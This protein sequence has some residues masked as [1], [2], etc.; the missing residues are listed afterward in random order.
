MSTF[1][2]KMCGGTLEIKQNAT[3]ATCD[4]CGTQQTLPKLD[5]EKRVSLYERANHFRRN[6]DF[7]KAMAVYEQ[8]LNEDQTDAEAYWS[9]VLCQY[10]I[11]YVEDP[12]S[13]RRIPTVNRVQFTSI[14][15]DDNYKSALKHADMYQRRIYEEEAKAINEIQKGILAIS[16]KEE[17]FDVFIC[18]KETDAIGKRTQDSV[19][20]QDLYYQL[21]QEGFKVFFAR[22]TL[23]D[24]LGSA[25]EPY[26]FAALNSAKV[27]VVLGTKPEH[28]NA[29]WVKNEWS[30]YLALVKNSKGQKMLIPAYRGMDPY[31]LPEE[32]SHLQAQ[33][34]SKLGF[35]QDLIRGIKK[36]LGRDKKPEA[37]VTER[38]VIQSDGHAQETAPL[39]RRAFLFLEDGEFD[40][41]DE[42]AEKVL[43]IDPECAEAY[44]VKLLIELRLRK[45]SDLPQCK[46][47]ISSSHNYQKAIRFAS[48][49]YRET[50][51][52]YNNAIINRNETAR[53]DSIYASGVEAMRYR[54]F[55]EAVEFFQRITNYKDS[56][57]KIEDCKKLKEE[58]RLNGIYQRAVQ[59][60]NGCAYDSAIALFQSIENYKD[61]QE[62]IKICRERKET[63]RKDSIYRQAMDRVSVP[64]NKLTDVDLKKS[65][66]ELQ[67]ISGYKDVDHQIRTLNTRLEKWYEDKRQ[68]EEAA[69]IK[70]EE[71]RRTQERLAEERRIKKEKQ[72]A[73]A[74]KVAKVGIPTVIAIAAVVV[75]LVTFIIPLIRYNQADELFNAG[76]YDEA[77]QIYQDI[78]GFSD[79]E[80]RIKVLYGINCIDVNDFKSGI[81]IILSAGVPVKLTYGMD[82][83]DFSGTEYANAQDENDDRIVFANASAMPHIIDPLSA[84]TEVSETVEFNYNSSAD[85]SGIQTPGRMGYRFV[86]WVLDSYS[87]QVDGIFELQ[88]NAIWSEKE[89][90]IS[91]DLDGG[92]VATNNPIEY[93]IEDSSFTLTNPTKTGYTFIGWTGTDLSEP[94]TSVTIATGSVGNRSYKAN[95][96]ANTYIITLNPN[97]GT[98]STKSITVTYDQP[99]SLPTPEWTGRNFSGWYE[100]SKK[101]ASG[102]WTRTSNLDLTAQWDIVEY[103]ITYN[104][105]G[106]VNTQSNPTTYTILDEI[107]LVQP[108]R[109]G[110]TFTG[111]TGTDLSEPT[112]VVVIDDCTGP[113]S[114]TA[115]WRANTYTITLDGNGV[116]LEDDSITV[117]YDKSYTLP[118]PTR[119]G[120]TFAGWYN[121]S[122]KY[123]G[124]TWKRTSD[125]KLTAKWNIITYNIS[126]TMNGGTNPSSN[127]KTYDVEDTITL[128]QPTKTG[129]TFAGWT[130]TGLSKPTMVVTISNLT[131]N[132][133]YTATWTAN[134][135]TITLDANG[136]ECLDDSITVTYDQP[137]TL[138]T[139]TRTGYTF[140]GWYDEIIKFTGGTWKHLSDVTLVAK[141]TANEYTLTYEDVQYA[142][143]HI[144]VTIDYNYSGSTTTTVTLLNGQSFWPPAS[145]SRSGYVF[146]GWYIDSACTTKYT[147]MGMSTDDF[148]ITEDIT[149]YAG[150]TEMSMSNVYSE[151][152]IYPAEYT[153]S[154]N[155]YSVS[156]SGT[157]SSSIKH[158]Y[159]VAQESGL[160]HIYWK[161]A[162]SSSYYGYYLRLYNITTGTTIRSS[163]NTYSTSYQSSSFTCSEGDVIVISLYRYNTNYTSTAYFYFDGLFS[164]PPNIIAATASCGTFAGLI[165][166]NDS[167]YQDVVAYDENYTLPTPTRPGYTFGGWYNGDTKIESGIWNYTTDMTLTARWTAN[168][169]TITLDANG[170]TVEKDSVIVTYDQEYTLPTPT[171]TGYIF[172]GWFDGETKYTGGA[173]QTATSITLVAKWTP[174]TDILYV[175][176]HHKQ[177][178]AGDGYEAPEVQAFIGTADATITP[179]V[180]SY[181]GFTSP[182]TQTVTIA[183]DGSLV[184]D[185]YY[186]RNSYTVTMVTNGGEEIESITQKYQ[187]DL[188][189]YY[190]TREGYTFGGWFTDVGLTTE[191][192]ENTM[193][194]NGA[195]VYAWWTEENKPTE[196]TYSGTS[197]I[198][199]NSYVGTSTTMWIPSY[200]GGTP[201]TTIPA[202][203]FSNQATITKVVVPDTVTSIGNR[204][205][206][207]CTELTTLTLGSDV[208]SIGEYAFAGCSLL[209]KFNSENE[210]ELIIPSKVETIGQYAFQDVLLVTKVVVPDSVT[211]I[212]LGVFKGC[213]AI[214]DIT[215]PFVGASANAK[216]PYAVFGY[217]FGYT[218]TQRTYSSA[219]SAGTYYSTSSTTYVDTQYSSV[220]GAIW[221]YSCYDYYGTVGY[222]YGYDYAYCFQSYF[223]HIPTTIKNVTITVQTD[224]PVAA[225]NNCDFIESI[226][227]PTD[228]TSIGEYAFAGCSLLSKFN[229]ENENELI[230]PS[231]VETIGQYAFQDVLLVTKVVVPDS[232][233]SIGLGAFKGCVAIEDITLPFVGNNID[234][235]SAFSTIFGTAPTTLRDITITVDTTMPASAFSGLSNVES[236]TIPNNTITIGSNAFQN[237]GALKQLN[238]TTD[239]VFNIPKDV[240]VINSYTFQNCTELTTLTLGSDVTSI[241]E[242][243]FAGCS[244]LN[245]FNSEN[246]NELIIPSKVE[247]IGQYAF[248]DVL[249][250]TKVVVPD[251]VTSI[252]LGAF[253]GCVAIEDITLPFVGNSA[254]VKYCDAVFGYVFGYNAVHDSNNY[255]WQSEFSESY[256]EYR[257]SKYG[258]LDGIWQYTAYTYTYTNGYGTR[259]YLES[260]YFCIPNSITSV[261]ITTQTDIPVA[262]F[263]NCEFIETINLP[264][265]VETHGSVGEYAFQNCAA[266]V[267]YNIVPTASV[268]WNGSKVATSYNSGSGTEEDPYVIFDGSQLKYFINQIN[269]GE[270]YQGK[271]FVIGSNINMGGYTIPVISPTEETAFAGVLDGNG[272]TITNFKVSAT[273]SV[274]GLFGYL[275]GILKGLGISSYTFSATVDSSSI[276]YTGVFVG[277]VMEGAT[278]DSCSVS[279]TATIT[280]TGSANAFASGFIGLNEGTVSNCAS[281]VA[282]TVTGDYT[283]YVGGFVA[284]NDGAITD[285]HASSNVSGTSN[286]FMAY[287][288]GFVGQNNGSIKGAFAS[289]N[290]TAKGSSES[291]SRNGGFVAENKGALEDCY[292]ASEQVL[293]K[294]TT[295]GDAYN[296]LATVLPL[297]EIEKLFK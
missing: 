103:G 154:S 178:I 13:H 16:Q 286:N 297:A 171:R 150:W 148:L 215:L 219:G 10:G 164:S 39:L 185:Y 239:G 14:F 73:Q 86:E 66:T 152:Q 85:F 38:V 207:N 293:T 201:V 279:G 80:Q 245:K 78:D 139:P 15:D 1:N 9:L 113:R 118:T 232:V 31:D 94:T 20:A 115:T 238:S 237:C 187:S 196:F 254:S 33:D 271:Y 129:Y 65:I 23:E 190:A 89:Y 104:L 58:D 274:N 142:Q 135:Y 2:C 195:T 265:T 41:A 173:W 27:M 77:M 83:G 246:E 98:V 6:N 203:A 210:N 217:I 211:S 126:Y 132:R 276:T 228:V 151:V 109:T 287:V 174:L 96:E 277:H 260:R 261:T 4:Y 281:D 93:S 125:L 184:V 256:K 128:A 267:N 119:T 223:Y 67:T 54:R 162:Y 123:T 233:T 47:P 224:I 179:A 263:N 204:V 155:Y 269:A 57:Q 222:Y 105:N 241:G 32:F 243:A 161:N 264:K 141:W 56:A 12:L 25:Y 42:Y 62:K 127:P 145:P 101:V 213:V 50:I 51:E 272:F 44:I 112:M 29:V 92:A 97:G 146:T 90:T 273:G 24:K 71:E 60:M 290:V 282:T 278:V 137:Y 130:G 294:Y 191:F 64:A 143:D 91:Y 100:G 270:T 59:F 124:G 192:T 170:G 186:T 266:T 214:E 72:K 68:A 280:S 283:I 240:E 147:S 106:G 21:T 208:T 30:R 7:D 5:D 18:Y 180:K 102:T 168:T 153:S 258:A 99:Y 236:I 131:S 259:H 218:G 206:Q 157:S 149:L 202:S 284:K 108:T 117:T 220:A 136:G 19:L 234:S 81:E 188:S 84:P 229:S 36:I 8:I 247:T 166:D 160:H 289:G 156:T 88:L 235:T 292:R 163:S 17:P 205:F 111:W 176:N 138:P 231:K 120:Y 3:V 133:S 249:L 244:L 197:A 172:E 209:S 252:G 200:I 183:P 34:M 82:G 288:G 74:I 275:K 52:G 255:V 253:K 226:T 26:I 175:V 251:S 221:Q 296:D 70:A 95:W 198:T 114:Y 110:Y 55:D 169:Y 76:K 134:T 189:L 193:P 212:G 107:T 158:I 43:D 268:K 75:L 122:T 248:Q 37:T 242:Y 250:V 225:F 61:S 140:D 22:I 69:R 79:S 257:N 181:T 116:V 194:L 182:S 46:N 199:I 53:K 121:G 167:T 177:N 49:K 87:Y 262:A 63:A 285:S 40:H 144:T 48:P 35:M 45:V 216:A 11:E 295:V 165:Y 291:Y 28:F 227:L 230:I 159:M